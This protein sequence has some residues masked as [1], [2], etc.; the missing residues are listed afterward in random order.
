MF[1][2][3]NCRTS[4]T[5]CIL[6]VHAFG[7][8]PLSHHEG[9]DAYIQWQDN[10]RYALHSAA[11]TVLVFTGPGIR[12]PRACSPA[13][14]SGPAVCEL[15]GEPILAHMGCVQSIWYTSTITYQDYTVGKTKRNET[16][17]RSHHLIACVGRITP[18]GGHL[19]SILEILKP[20]ATLLLQIRARHPCD[21]DGGI[22]HPGTVAHA[23]AS[24]LFFSISQ[25]RLNLVAS[26]VQVEMYLHNKPQGRIKHSFWVLLLILYFNN[27]FPFSLVIFFL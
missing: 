2:N 1:I 23:Q 24:C 18:I 11:V 26:L 27:V 4:V 9:T 7:G 16:K 12:A 14:D 20:R 10:D 13:R 3:D 25:S 6:C 17:D 8:I 21:N 15:A 5:S 22:V 19:L